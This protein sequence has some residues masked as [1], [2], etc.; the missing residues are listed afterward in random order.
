MAS[1]KGRPSGQRPNQTILGRTLVLAFVCGI[2]EFSV[3]AVQLYNLMIR[4]HAF[5]EE[6]AVRQQTRSTA[7]SASRGTIYDANGN[8]M[9]MSATAYTVF[10][11]P[12]E[13]KYYH[14]KEYKDNEIHYG[15]EPTLIARGLSEI[16]DVDYDRIMTQMQDT[17]SWYKTVAV[18][19]EAD[20]AD[21][22]RE[23]KAQH[24][25]VGV[26][27][28][29]DTK[30]YYPNGSLAC[31]VIGF[32]GTENYG[33]EGIEA[34]YDEKLEGTNGSVVR[35]V[36]N[37]GTE[38]LFE[39]YQN[40]NDAV[41][42]HDITLTLDSSIQGIA[43]KYL[44]QAMSAN[45][46]QNGGCVIVMNVKTGEILGLANANGYDLNDPWGLP[47]DVL[48]EIALL[49]EEER[50]KAVRDAQTAQWRNMALS[51]TYEP[52][53]VFKIITMA[54]GLEEGLI[55]ENSTFFCGGKIAAS[56]IPGRTLDLN[57][58]KH[59][60]HGSQNLRESAMHSCNVAFVNIGMSIGAETYY[61]Y[62]DAFGLRSKTGIDLSGESGSIWWPDKDFKN[63]QD[64][65]SLAAASFG[66]TFNVTPIQM[67]TAVSA[68]VNGGY[69]ME[70]YIVSEIRNED[71]EVIYSREPTVIRQVISEE[72]SALVADI[73]GSVV[74]DEGGTGSNARVP[75]YSIGGKTGTT[76][77]T[78][79][80]VQEITEHMVSF[81]GIA[82]TDD[83][84]I[85]VLLVLDNP[86]E[87]SG[88]YVG[89]GQM[90]AP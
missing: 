3:L 21:K 86:D 66:Q 76:T 45:H 24:N 79:Q 88:I 54:I 16:L 6:K 20:L 36:T 73:L 69:L 8:I 67:I 55:S 77:K 65:S 40:Y 74:N 63:P 29:E 53:S 82:P 25:I 46:I 34:L 56:Q 90:A 2:V 10:I 52:G 4:D 51:D 33:L 43:E 30:R 87:N 5:Y 70:P 14:E 15:D 71:G 75:G 26:H 44:Q 11:S 12:Y 85:A 19:I 72:T 64:K 41:D 80:G 59:A 84:E 58:W 1:S 57:C 39:N 61:N 31:H 18:K 81:C 48:E 50:S 35:L 13:I 62:V 42:G 47:E 23:F 38:M 83:P 7:V 60:G 68:A 28:E 32:V 22:V 78:V 89:G 37:T 49:P 9:A 17:K 27:I